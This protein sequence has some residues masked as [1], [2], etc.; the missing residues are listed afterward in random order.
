MGVAVQAS[1][2][3][4]GAITAPTTLDQIRAG[5][6]TAFAAVVAAYDKELTRIAYV[7]CGDIDAARDATQEAWRKLWSAPPELRDP[8][9]LRSWLITV[10]ANAARQTLRR[11]RRATSALERKAALDTER[12][13]DLEHRLDV[14]SALEQLSAED[15][16]LFAYRFVA[17]LTSAEIGRLYGLSAEGV[18]SRLHRVIARLREELK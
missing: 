4:F 8:D 5:D 16:E 6:K 14:R 7:V 15:R 9:R 1:A 11:R 12:P 17:E 10:A 13:V 2:G 3:G 18:R